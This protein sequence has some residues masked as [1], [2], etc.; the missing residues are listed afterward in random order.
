MSFAEIAAV[1]APRSA[2]PSVTVST[3]TVAP[4]PTHQRAVGSG[5][6]RD[7][8]LISAGVVQQ[9]AA[10]DLRL[11]LVSVPVTDIECAKAFYVDQVGFRV[12]Q[13]VQVDANHALWS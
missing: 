3:R 1:V 6:S 4:K 10:I 5:R 2:A 7:S 9:G 12:E 11:E 13:D 8:V